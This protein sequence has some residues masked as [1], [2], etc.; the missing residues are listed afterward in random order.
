MSQNRRIPFGYKMENGEIT[1]EPTEAKAVA[2]IFEDYLAGSSLLDIAK[3]MQDIG[4]P[5]HPHGVCT[6]NRN[7][8][9]RILENDRY[10]GT[11]KYPQLV[12]EIKFK[13]VNRLKSQKA[14][15][16]CIVPDELT[17]LRNMTVCSECRKRLFRNQN[18]T[19]NCKTVGCCGF[20]HTVTDHM[21][22]SAVLNM[23]NSAIANPS[24][25]D[26]GGEISIYTPNGYVTRQ[27]NEINRLCDSSDID[28]DRIKAEIMKLAEIKYD[29]CSYDDVPQKT[30]YLKKLFT[31][32]EQLNSLDIDLLK[33]CVGHI[34]VSHYACICLEMINGVRLINN[35]ERKETCNECND[36]SSD[37]NSSG[38][39]SG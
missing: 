15:N 30:Q 1:A 6:W 31:E 9:K 2:K 29:C 3:Q 27:K 35:T 19:W 17:E 37:Q 8:V 36:N 25:L 34:L 10:L 39:R 18:G 38:G 20:K 28:Y 7:M 16:L 5:Y 26:A 12:D 23:L 13:Q 4:V 14:T 32:K 21:I 33:L 11:D 22:I 24:L